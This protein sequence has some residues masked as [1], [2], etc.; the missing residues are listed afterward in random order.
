VPRDQ[1]AIE[2]PVTAA[3]ALTPR[4]LRAYVLLAHARERG[5]APTAAELAGELFH[6]HGAAGRPLS[7]RTARRLLD[8]LAEAGW[9][10]LGPRAGRQ[11]RHQIAVLSSPVRSVSP[12]PP[13]DTSS[14][15]AAC[16]DTHDGSGPDDHD[17]SLATK[18]DQQVSPDVVRGGGVFRRRRT[19]GSRAVDTGGNPRGAV[20]A[21]LGPGG[22]GLRPEGP[23]RPHGHAPYAGPEP[24]LSR[25]AHDALEPVQHLLPALRPYVLRQIRR[26]IARQLRAGVEVAQLRWRLEHRYAT[27]TPPRDPGRWLLGVGLTERGCV[28]EC[29]GGWIWRT[30]MTCQVCAVRDTGPRGVPAPAAAPAAPALPAT[31]APPRL[32]PP[33][34]AP[35]RT[36]CSCPDCHATA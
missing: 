9:L 10:D 2:V 1:A 14:G 22:C 25:W 12:E 29:E 26:E 16:P 13:V 19:T 30:G 6:H 32:P 21:D 8:Q 17:G 18:D 11:G 5:L 15:P 31:P 7:E 3:D 36:W 34:R 28:P 33:R 35:M 20:Q 27:W 4:Q 23:A 24:T